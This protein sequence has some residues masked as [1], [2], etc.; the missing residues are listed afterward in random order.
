[1]PVMKKRLTTSEIKRS[2]NRDE[3]ATHYYNNAGE[4]TI[5]SEDSPQT[6]QGFQP[7]IGTSSVDAVVNKAM[8]YIDAKDS[9]KLETLFAANFIHS[10]GK[11]GQKQG[12]KI[13]GHAHD[14]YYTTCEVQPNIEALFIHAPAKFAAIIDKLLE[15]NNTQLYGIFMKAVQSSGFS[16]PDLFRWD[17]AIKQNVQSQLNQLN[18]YGFAA[19]HH[20]TKQDDQDTVY[21]KGLKAQG[22]VRSIKGEIETFDISHQTPNESHERQLQNLKLK[23][24][25]LKTL[26]SEDSVFD[27]HR[28]WKRVIANI[29]S[30]V[31]TGGVANAINYAATGSFWFGNKTARAQL[32][33]DA[34]K[35]M[36]GLERDKDQKFDQEG[37]G[38]SDPTHP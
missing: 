31:L 34:H 16:H 13:R 2:V 14:T 33:A 26:H 7:I 3:V 10:I 15:S 30:F 25:I 38:F 29:T 4:V 36:M 12:E 19:A 23:M 22:I 20:G 18:T 27:V 28:G 24:D 1:M 21:K 35:E 11:K 6:P 5:V 9:K 8:E 32:V 17:S 37:H